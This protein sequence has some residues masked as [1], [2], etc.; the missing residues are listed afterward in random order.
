MPFIMKKT[1]TSPIR[2][3]FLLKILLL[4]GNSPQ[5]GIFLE[6]L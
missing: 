3:V 6:E 4:F 2:L 5:V 1:E